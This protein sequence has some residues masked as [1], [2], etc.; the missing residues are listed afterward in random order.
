MIASKSSDSRRDVHRADRQLVHRQRPANRHRIAVTV[1]DLELADGDH[2]RLQIDA[3]VEAGVARAQ[4][5]NRKRAA[6]A[7]RS[8]RRHAGRSRFQ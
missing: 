7:S 2:V 3:G 5:G 4:L 6:A 8:R 1:E